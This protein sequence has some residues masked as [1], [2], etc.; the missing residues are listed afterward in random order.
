MKIYIQFK[1]F[2]KINSGRI[3]ISNFTV[4]VGENNSGK[5]FVMQLIYAVQKE[6]CNSNIFSGEIIDIADYV[7]IN[8]DIIKKIEAEINRYLGSNK[9]RII[10][11][12]FHR[13]I[14]IGKLKVD[15]ELYDAKIYIKNER[16]DRVINSD[17][18][19]KDTS[20][21]SIGLKVP[22][23][24]EVKHGL[25]YFGKDDKY[26]SKALCSQVISVILGSG[27][28]SDSILFL[29]ASRTGMQLLYKYFFSEKDKKENEL[30][31]DYDFENK[32]EI[33]KENELGLTVPVYDFLQFLLRYS[34]SENNSKENS[35]LIKFIESNLIDGE[36][37]EN[38][39]ETLYRQSVEDELTPLYLASSMVN[40]ISPIFK[41]L[42]GKVN[43]KTLLYDE[44]ETCL[45]PE[46]QKQMARLLVRM[47]NAGYKLIVST[48]SDTMAAK[49]NNLLM[50]T[51]M[52]EN[53][54]QENI[55][56]KL[57]KLNL[58]KEDL[59]D[60]CE[61]HVYQFVCEEKNRST[62]KELEFNP[63][64]KVGYDFEQFAK[65]AIDLYEETMQ[66]VGE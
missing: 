9:E 23:K 65:S 28:S 58:Q 27:Y 49:L 63:V 64:T 38:G 34:V 45:H 47:N 39:G 21:V 42:T 14:P 11:K 17:G 44:I 29:P 8:T 3:D 20:Y 18:D 55:D 54:K 36:L 40:E 62:I 5:T 15:I 57:K 37:L 51:Y 10:E 16:K 52:K 24:K 56:E 53:Y 46:K 1:D 6:I 31:F 30:M 61:F 12:Y 32:K 7:D 35:G 66:I 13:A 25:F 33:R 19:R 59:L 26:L 60:S 48:H 22:N 50:L 4:F 41:V 43:Y 2:G